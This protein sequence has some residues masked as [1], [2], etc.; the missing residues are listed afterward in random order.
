MIILKV[1]SSLI[2]KK[3]KLEN[4]LLSLKGTLAYKNKSVLRDY[5]NAIGK[6][7]R[8][9]T[10]AK[11]GPNIKGYKDKEA[12][13][14]AFIKYRKLYA[15]NYQNFIDSNKNLL[16]GVSD[17]GAINANLFITTQQKEIE[18][19]EKINQAYLNG[20]LTKSDLQKEIARNSS[21]IKRNIFQGR[22][23]KA[24][25]KKAMYKNLEKQYL[26]KQV[27]N[28]YAK[29][30]R[31]GSYE[32]TDPRESER[33]QESLKGLRRSFNSRDF[34]EYA[35]YYIKKVGEYGKY[36][37]GYEYDKFG[38]QQDTTFVELREQ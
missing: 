1:I 37:E 16:P 23:T 2:D 22:N 8:Q 17:R 3:T 19:S 6:L 9:I 20:R 25:Q 15:E 26:E 21:R 36:E 12:A 7:D 33:I 31:D 29:R 14:K 38:K 11:R 30:K 27:E 32:I 4:E 13:S 24:Q 10:R 28:G 34:E 18:R 5:N 35:N